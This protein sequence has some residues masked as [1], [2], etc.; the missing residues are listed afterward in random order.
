MSME[1]VNLAEKLSRF[2]DHWSPKIVGEVQGM[3][4]KLVKLQGEF[5]WHH[6]EHED[7]MFFVVSGRLLIKFRDRDVWLDPGEFQ[8]A[9]LTRV[10]LLTAT[11]PSPSLTGCKQQYWIFDH[12]GRGGIARPFSCHRNLRYISIT[13]LRVTQLEEPHA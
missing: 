5:V 8:P 12:K 13:L 4:V 2:S 10:A 6:H 3:H 11:R 7:E 1:K 9:R